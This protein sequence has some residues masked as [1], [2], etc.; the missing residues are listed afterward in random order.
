MIDE[1]ERLTT[2]QW[3]F[4]RQLAWIIAADTKIAAVVAIDTALLAGIAAA[5]SASSEAA[6]TEWTF[7]WAILSGTFSLL[8]LGCAAI[9]LH[10]KTTGPISSALFFGRIAELSLPDYRDKLMST[11][12]KDL[13]ED[14][15]NQIH[16]NAEIAAFKYKWVARCINWSFLAAGPWLISVIKF[17][18]P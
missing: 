14:W 6:R 12:N 16:R 9:A 1:K 13:L 17:V 8:S 4:E 15:A 11:A 7:A 3:I 5:Y 10:P 2:A 18:R